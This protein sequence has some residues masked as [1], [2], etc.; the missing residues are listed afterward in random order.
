MS[1]FFTD[2]ADLR[3]TL[4]DLALARVV[5]L[6]EDDYAQASEFTYAP[7]DFEDA[8]DSYERVLEIA[9]EIAGEYIEPRAEDVDRAGSELVAGEV[10]YARGI[11]EGLER[12][13]QADLMGMTLPRRYGGLNLPVSVS[14][15]VIEMVSRADPALMNIFGLQDISETINKF[16]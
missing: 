9:G 10:C 4:R 3:R 11:A 16:A 7:R 1:N 6:R 8:L 14:V 15:M 12:L 2:N 13:R 5:R